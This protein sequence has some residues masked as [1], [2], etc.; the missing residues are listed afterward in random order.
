MRKFMALFFAF[1]AVLPRMALAQTQPGS[2]PIPA[3][4]HSRS[5]TKRKKQALP[6]P[7]FTPIDVNQQSFPYYDSDSG[8]S[9]ATA[10]SYSY[11]GS[12]L[13]DPKDFERVIYPL[14]DPQADS[15]LQSA[16]NEDGWGQGFLWGG[17]ALEAAGWTD[18]TVEMLNMDTPP[19]HVP[20][21]V[22]STL[23]ILGGV[24]AIVKGVFTQIDASTDR[25]SAVERYNAVVQTDNNLSM[26]VMPGTQA[27]GL[28]LTQAF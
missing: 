22:P 17:I 12:T 24:G 2:T 18:F 20:N 23:M 3:F 11:K 26:M 14:Q 6:N 7:E 19:D 13:S 15:L 4:S 21:M 1:L 9:V 10:T 5:K 16:A 25:A 8:W 28:S 27:V